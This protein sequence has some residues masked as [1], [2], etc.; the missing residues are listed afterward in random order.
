VKQV[1]S[2]LQI[3]LGSPR[4][5]LPLRVQEVELLQPLV[6]S[7]SQAYIDHYAATRNFAHE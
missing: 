3:L 2:P 5:L 7:I 1:Q 6:D 4:D